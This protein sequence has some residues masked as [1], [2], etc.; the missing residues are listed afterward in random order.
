MDICRSLKLRPT[1]I[2]HAA[3]SIDRKR[4]YGLTNLLTS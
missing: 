3:M 4:L 1:N 2:I